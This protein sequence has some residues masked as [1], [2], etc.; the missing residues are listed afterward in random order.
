MLNKIQHIAS[1]QGIKDL[2]ERQNVIQDMLI[3]HRPQATGITPYEATRR[4]TVKIKLDHINP[5]MKTSPK[6]DIINP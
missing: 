6:D 1:L 5:E 4:T 3:A 2:F